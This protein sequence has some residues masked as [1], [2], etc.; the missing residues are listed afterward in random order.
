MYDIHMTYCMAWS[1]PIVKE[2]THQSAVD[3][4]AKTGVKIWKVYDM[5]IA[6]L[7]TSVSG[8]IPQ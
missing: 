3:I 1:R 2:Q 4:A 7:K 5:A 8:E 6:N